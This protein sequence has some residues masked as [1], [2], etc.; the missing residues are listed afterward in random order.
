M[1]IKGIVPPSPIKQKGLLKK[2]KD[3]SFI[4]V[5]SQEEV[6]GALQPDAGSSKTRLIFE[7]YGGFSNNVFFIA[8]CAFF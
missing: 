5:W 7:L 3:P 8:F 2:V 6:F 1:A 4:A